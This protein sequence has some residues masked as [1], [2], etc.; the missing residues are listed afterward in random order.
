MSDAKRQILEMLETG[1]ITGEDAERLLEALG[2]ETETA[3]ENPMPNSAREAASNVKE[4][5]KDF[6]PQLTLH[7]EHEPVDLEKIL[8]EPPVTDT[9]QETV[10]G[11]F[12]AAK[13]A[14]SSAKQAVSKLSQIDTKLTAQGSQKFSC[15][16]LNEINVQWA[17]CEVLVQNWDG[18]TVCVT[19]YANRPLDPNE[20]MVTQD[21]EGTLT[22]LWSE[23]KNENA[24]LNPLQKRLVIELPQQL[25]SLDTMEIH[26]GSAKI[27][28]NTPQTSF[29]TIELSAGSGAVFVSGVTADDFQVKTGS[30]AITLSQVECDNL[31]AHTGSGSI[32]AEQLQAE[33]VELESGSGS[34]TADSIVSAEDVQLH[35]ASGSVKLTANEL[36]ECAELH[37]VSGSVTVTLPGEPEGGFTV[38][39][40]TVS[41]KFHCDFPLEDA[42]LDK[43][44]G[45]GTYGDGAC[46]LK[47]STTTGSMKICN[48]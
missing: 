44:S 26:T 21:D 45:S 10:K 5:V 48:A 29:D 14:I 1:T 47:L 27:Q 37:S 39:Y 9:V 8:G 6:V 16:N 22:I 42:E 43:R 2:D 25:A 28:L 36:P 18:D 38:E 31:N 13:E 20:C 30:G 11:I 34:I 46:E 17:A 19:E 40:D 33:T 35:T 32:H 12:G 15:D 24:F 23:R 4:N 3:P 7:P 41:G